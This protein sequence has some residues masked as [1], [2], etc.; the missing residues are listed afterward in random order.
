MKLLFLLSVMVFME[1]EEPATKT[2]PIESLDKCNTIVL[3]L[4]QQSLEAIKKTDK[5]MAYEA[6]CT[7]VS[8]K[9]GDPA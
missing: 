4:Q 1:G 5:P 7:I 9:D 2:W 3:T 8:E 6:W